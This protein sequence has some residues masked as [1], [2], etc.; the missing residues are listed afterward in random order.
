MN[1]CISSLLKHII[2]SPLLVKDLFHRTNIELI[3]KSNFELENYLSSKS[4]FPVG[5]S[6]GKNC[7][8]YKFDLQIVVPI[9][10][11]EEYLE[12]CLDS[13]I[14]QET[15]YSY[16]IVLIND[17]S[18]DNSY[19][20]IKKYINNPKVRLINQE[21]KGHSGARN[22]GIKLIEAK[23]ISFVDSDDFV[24]PLFVEQMVNNALC[25]DADI[26]QCRMFSFSN[27]HPKV[28][29]NKYK[30]SKIDQENI[31]GITC[32]KVY[33]SDIFSNLVFPDGFWF[34]DSIYLLS[35]A[36]SKKMNCYNLSSQLYFYRDNKNGVTSTSIGKL[37]TI[38][39]YWITKLL[40]SETK[41]GVSIDVTT[42]AL[43]KQFLCN[44]FRVYSLPKD[45]QNV[46][47]ELTRRLCIELI[48]NTVISKNKI[49]DCIIKGKYYKLLYYAK[50]I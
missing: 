44:C 2:Y 39:T 48:H 7:I 10:N 15:S 34:E 35:I 37:K 31:S 8:S 41:I 17:G 14:N 36:L 50:T 26:V 1:S 23:Y 47:F 16:I 22:A 6:K 43:S 3:N 46:V 38:D 30:I 45:I 19:E 32:C 25:H 13:L 42:E 29:N 18:T 27:K 49:I 40:L 21:N 28:K 5:T 4:P 11:S 33:K 24:S 12:Q 9:Y 20:I